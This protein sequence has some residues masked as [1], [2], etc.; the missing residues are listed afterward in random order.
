MVHLGLHRKTQRQV[1][2]K[3]LKKEMMP[4]E[5]IGLKKT[6]IEIL[7]LCQHPNIIRLYDVFEN[8]RYIFMV[9]EFLSGGD[10]STFLSKQQLKINEKQAAKIMSTLAA[11]VYYL[12]SYG[13]IH[14]DLK[15]ENIL[16]V[17]NTDD[18]DAKI[19]D[20]GLARI[21]SPGEKCVEPFG[22]LGYAAPEVI[23]KTPYSK[24]VDIWSLGVIAYLLLYGTLPFEDKKDSEQMVAK[25]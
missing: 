5:E 2:V 23:C 22:T 14:R 24:S 6:E 18:S 1:A 3:I 11:A 21:M 20:F 17:D 8:H 16:L 7:K 10:L 12:H 15:P 13:I 4:A 25:Y 19:V 9:M